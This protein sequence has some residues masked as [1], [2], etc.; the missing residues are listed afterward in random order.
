MPEKQ[1]REKIEAELN[2]SEPDRAHAAWQRLIGSLEELE[3]LLRDGE[4]D[5]SL[6][7]KLADLG[8][9]LN[10]F[11]EALDHVHPDSWEASEQKSAANFLA[12]VVAKHRRKT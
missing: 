11:E 2:A 10:T 3:Q 7:E 9:R 1:T 4:L 6:I 8:D 5:P 12:D